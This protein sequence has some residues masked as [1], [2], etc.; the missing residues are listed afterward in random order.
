VCVHSNCIS[1]LPWKNLN[2]NVEKILMNPVDILTII[3]L[4]LWM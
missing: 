4:F 3:V 2:Q 1:H